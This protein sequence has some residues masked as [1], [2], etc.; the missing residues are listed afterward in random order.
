MKPGE[1]SVDKRRVLMAV[2]H[3]RLSARGDAGDLAGK[4]RMESRL[5]VQHMERYAFRAQHVA[6]G[7]GRVEAAD[8][9]AGRA[10][11]ATNEL[12]DEPLS[13]TWC[14]G[15]NDLKNGWMSDARLPGPSYPAVCQ[16]S[17]R[18]AR[19]DDKRPQA[20]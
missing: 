9:L 20:R 11:R 12:D 19:A 15:K 14:Q 10:R 18:G 1:R 3:V 4:S 7:A 16:C 8:G 13:S 6:P 17:P 5:T 2:Q